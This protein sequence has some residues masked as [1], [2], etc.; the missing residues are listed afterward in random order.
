MVRRI[1]RNLFQALLRPFVSCVAGSTEA[2]FAISITKYRTSSP[3]RQQSKKKPF[4]W[5]VETF[6]PPLTAGRF[7]DKITIKVFFVGH[8]E[9]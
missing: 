4:D 5:A 1:L 6:L 7:G 2:P 8:R 9:D 3:E